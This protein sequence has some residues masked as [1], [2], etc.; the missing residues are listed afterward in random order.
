MVPLTETAVSLEALQVS[1]DGVPVLKGVDLELPRGTRLLLTGGNGA[2]KTTLLK[3]IMGLVKPSAGRC[4]LLNNDSIASL[5]S[6]GRIGYLN[7]NSVEVKFPVSAY[8]VVEIGVARRGFSRSQRRT[9]ILRAMN[10][11]GSAHLAAKP[12]A[13]LS[14]GEK[15]RVSLAR[16]M[17]QNPEILLLDE[18]CASLDSTAKST[19]LDILD[20]IN[21]KF[22]TTVFMVSHA[23]ET[24]HRPGWLHVLL[25]NGQLINALDGQ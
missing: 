10:T 7:Q 18:P 23:E 4:A 8:E 19:L 3:S 25:Q 22:G 21:A 9:E 5:R 15:Q 17:A 13:K 14:G 6:S 24:K 1:L 12:F 20:E 11:T 16:C 2:G